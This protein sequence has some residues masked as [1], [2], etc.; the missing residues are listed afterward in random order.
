MNIKLLIGILV[1]GAVLIGGCVKTPKKTAPPQPLHTEEEAVEIAKGF[2]ANSPT[3]RWDGEDMRVID[4]LTLR[5]P[6][7]WE[8]VIEFQCR[9]GGYGDRTGKIV[10]QVITPHVARIVVEKGEVTSAILDNK[11]DEINQRTLYIG[12]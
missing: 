5:C 6:Y 3:Y 1:I 4:V 9:H 10:I 8:V 7:C 11:W 2:L 12:C